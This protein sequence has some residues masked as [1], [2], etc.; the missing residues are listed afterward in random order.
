[1]IASSGFSAEPIKEALCKTTS[2]NSICTM[3]A[4]DR[5]LSDDEASS[6]WSEIKA[7]SASTGDSDSEEDE[8]FSPA[9][10][11]N[12]ANNVTDFA[13]DGEASRPI[14][15]SQAAR[16][17]FEL[18]RG[19]AVAAEAKARFESRLEL[20]E[21]DESDSEDEFVRGFGKCARQWAVGSQ[22]RRCAQAEER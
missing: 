17:N 18:L 16:A 21:D 9:R 1:M 15:P 10:I 6:Y 22:P 12:L 3:D 5:Q 13:N 14:G 19:L 20:D 8:T 7:S 4:P 2:A 11:T